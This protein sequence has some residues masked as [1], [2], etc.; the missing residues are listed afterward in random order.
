MSTLHDIIVSTPALAGMTYAE[1]AAW[2]DTREMVD[3]P[4]KA[5]PM[6]PRRI[7]M[8]EV[9]QAVAVAAPAD[10]AKAG[11]IPGWLVDRAEAAMAADDRDGMANYLT[12]IAATAQLSAASQQALAALLASKE[13]DPAW[14]AQIP[15]PARWQALG[16]AAAPTAA[17]VQAAA[18]E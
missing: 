12:T 1:I 17:D 10:L 7:T 9:F 3:N 4:V 11:Q 16:L 5:A 8:L 2:L 18:H 14:S 13:K 6:V 15:D